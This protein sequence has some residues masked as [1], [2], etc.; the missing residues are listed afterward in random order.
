MMIQVI[1]IF[2]L[3]EIP[4]W[5]YMV[6]DLWIGSHYNS[7]LQLSHISPTST[8]TICPSYTYISSLL[9]NFCPFC[10]LSLPN[11]TPFS[12]LFSPKYLY[13]ALYL[14]PHIYQ[15]FILSSPTYL[16]I[17][18]SFFH[19][20]LSKISPTSTTSNLFSP[21]FSPKCLSLV[22][23]LLSKYS[24]YISPFST[25]SSSNISQF[26]DK[27]TWGFIGKLHLQ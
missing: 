5:A 27:Q 13:S 20:F 11:I 2:E 3:N 4:I 25:L 19:A 21:K 6:L 10:T 7:L 17:F 22:R 18:H 15:F 12:N 14:L 16:S 26:F 24:I 23:Y 1:L 9:P 8:I